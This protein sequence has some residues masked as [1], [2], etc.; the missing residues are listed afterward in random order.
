MVTRK[1]AEV[2][3][4]IAG[5]VMKA[6]ALAVV[7]I[8]LTAGFVVFLYAVLKLDRPIATG[9]LGGIDV[10]LGVLLRQVYGSLFPTPPKA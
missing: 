10:L 4:I 6:V 5:I 2:A 7:L 9:I 1:Q 8:L 3:E